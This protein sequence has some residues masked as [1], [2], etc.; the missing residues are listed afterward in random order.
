MTEITNRT[1]LSSNPELLPELL[2]ENPKAMKYQYCNNL[3]STAKRVV[4]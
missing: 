1:L 4:I 3:L 2:L